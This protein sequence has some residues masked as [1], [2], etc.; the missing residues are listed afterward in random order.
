[1]PLVDRVEQVCDG[2]TL[3]KPHRKPFPQS[4]SFRVS[5]GLEPV[6]ADLCGKI[7]PPTPGGKLYFLL[8]VD[9]HSRYM[10]VELLRTK[11]EALS[12][13]KKIKQQAELEHEK[14]LKALRTDRGGEF[15]SNL[16]T[17][18][19]NETGIKHYT[20][21]PYSPQQNGVVERYNQMV[22]EM[23]RCMLKTKKMPP[24]FWGEAIVTAVFI[25]NRAPTKSLQN[26][27]QY[28]AWHGK[29]PRVDHLKAIGSI[30]HVKA[31]GPSI[32]K[33]SDRSIKM[34]FLG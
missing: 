13:F 27:T 16:F 25:L 31:S 20:T 26:K 9:D 15:N 5:Q 24:K 23:A 28:E 7:N 17:V 2:C 30:A 1:M 34:V 8:V 21:T 32:M 14:K 4:S 22:V 29:K 12:Y 10:S 3:G 19:C 6:H 18:F 33:L 11:D